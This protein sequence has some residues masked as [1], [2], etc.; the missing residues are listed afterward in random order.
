MLST[1]N[2]V[3][4][5]FALILVG[6]LARKLKILGETA[7]TELNRFVVYLALPA[8]LFDIIANAMWADLAQPAFISAFS[9]GMMVV[10]F[11]TL[12]VQL[13]RT[14]HLADAAIDALNAGYANTGFIGFPLVIVF[15]GHEALAPTLIATILTVSVLFG[16]GI[17]IIETGLQ[18]EVKRRIIFTRV[19]KSL[20]KNPLLVSPAI[21]ICIPLSGLTV[22]DSINVFLKLLGGAASPCALI[23]LG[24]FLAGQSDKKTNN[25]NFTVTLLVVLKLLIQPALTWW[26][27]TKVFHLSPLLVHTAV[28]LAALPTGTGPFMLAEFYRREASTTSK[29]VLVSTVLSMFTLS[30]YLYT[31]GL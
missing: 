1:L 30:A 19:A 23:A 27:A 7:L 28:L 20:I 29:C 17:I 26:F 5:V 11:L 3:L 16:I 4:P 12:F 14:R 9:I 6:W 10:F 15:L 13:R 25:D 24:L 8:L 21:A 31:I 18:G 22:P 2:V